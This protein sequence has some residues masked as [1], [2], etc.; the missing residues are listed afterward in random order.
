MYSKWLKTKE[1]NTEIIL[2]N[3]HTYIQYTV[4]STEITNNVKVDNTFQ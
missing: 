4:N 1:K 3:R 2:K